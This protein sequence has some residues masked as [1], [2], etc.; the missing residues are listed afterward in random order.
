V[1]WW[2]S[3]ARWRC[4]WLV[5]AAADGRRGRVAR[6]VRPGPVCVSGAAREGSADGVQRGGQRG[7]GR[8]ARMG[9]ASPVARA[10]QTRLISG[11]WPHITPPV[12]C[13]RGRRVLCA[14]LP[15]AVTGR[16]GGQ[17]GRT[18]LRCHQNKSNACGQALSRSNH[19]P[20][21]TRSR[22]NNVLRSFRLSAIGLLILLS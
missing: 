7:C 1:R 11:L 17:R 8:A 15:P 19:A 2:V 6:W 22:S 16:V 14:G 4:G 13:S 5:R 21:C 10:L 3:G 12:W 9:R 18:W 20:F